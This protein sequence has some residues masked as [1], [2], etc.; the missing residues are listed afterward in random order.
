[1]ENVV[2]FKKQIDAKGQLG[3]WNIDIDEKDLM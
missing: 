2:P 3:F 1:M